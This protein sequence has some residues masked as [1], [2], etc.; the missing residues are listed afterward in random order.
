MRANMD[1]VDS[2]IIHL[3]KRNGRMRNTEMAKRLKISET[4]IR[5][6]L[7]RLFD[8]EVIQ[9]VAIVNHSKIG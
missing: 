3:L 2:R 9:V 1:E 8:N 5:K 6:R 4:S 7:Q